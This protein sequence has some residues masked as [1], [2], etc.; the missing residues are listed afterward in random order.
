MAATLVSRKPFVIPQWT[1]ALKPVGS[2]LIPS[3]AEFL[4][5]ENRTVA[6]RGLIASV[7]GSFAAETPDAYARLEKSLAETNKP[8]ASTDAKTALAKK[9][10]SLGVALL[11]MGK[12]EKSGRF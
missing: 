12:G 11:V 9:Q 4:V 6:E 7:Y 10:A 5:D 2:W 3:L 1:G 8:D